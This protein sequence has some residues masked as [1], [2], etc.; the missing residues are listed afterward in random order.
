MVN[1]QMVGVVV[2]PGRALRADGGQ[3]GVVVVRWRRG[4]EPL[5]RMAIPGVVTGRDRIAP[6]DDEV[7]EKQKE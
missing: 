2:V 7:D 3:A 6:R 5:E 4:G 1:G